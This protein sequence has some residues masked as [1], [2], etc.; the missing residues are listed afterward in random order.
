MARKSGK[1]KKVDED[2]LTPAEEDRR[3]INRF[4]E[5]DEEAF[6]QLM[7]RYRARVTRMVGRIAGDRHE[8]EEILQE[9]F[10]TVYRKLSQ[11]E[12][13]SS[14][15]TWLYRVAVNAALMRIR[16]RKKTESVSLDGFP[17]EMATTEDRGESGVYEHL[18]TEQSLARIEKA[19]EPLPYDFKTVIIL[20]DI[21]GF[22]SEETAEIMQL[23]NAAVKSRLHRA[24]IFLRERLQDLYRET[25]ES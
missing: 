22:S 21:E 23:S 24:R 6:E 12:G 13:K 2:R 10:L 3:L 4:L 18:I 19:I 25:I 1:K 5:G 15:S 8:A 14:F 9:V 17:E 20:R 7:K 16:S 11:F